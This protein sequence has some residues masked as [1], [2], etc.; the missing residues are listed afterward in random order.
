MLRSFCGVSLAPAE[1][2]L[3]PFAA[4]VGVVGARPLVVLAWLDLFSIVRLIK[5]PMQR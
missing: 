4:V 5:T 2:H 3:S 1:K